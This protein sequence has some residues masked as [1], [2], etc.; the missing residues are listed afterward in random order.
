MPKLRVLLDENLGANVEKAF[1]KK[2]PVYTVTDFGVRRAED[3]IVIEKAV[4]KKC[5]IVTANKDFVDHY[6][7]HHWR[8]GRDGRFF[9]GL[10]FLKHS[11]TLTRL[12]Q[13]K[14]AAKKI[15]YLHDDLITVS[16]TGAV[17]CERLCGFD[18]ASEHAV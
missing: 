7:K 18:C 17:K 8:D 15:N 5:L 9:Y 4:A 13:L 2:V 12:Q 1:S 3:R 6:K 10:I 11:T 14:R 16:A